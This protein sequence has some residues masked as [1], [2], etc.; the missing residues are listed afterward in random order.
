V[1]LK[2]AVAP[3][4]PHTY[5]PCCLILT[6]PAAVS[7]KSRCGSCEI[8]AVGPAKH[9]AYPAKA[10]FN[11]QNPAVCPAKP[12]CVSCRMSCRARSAGQAGQLAVY[13]L[14]V[15]NSVEERLL[16]LTDR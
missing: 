16:Q 7:A 13:R 8:P 11:L 14:V 15:R 3:V 6:N 1:P 4:C 5:M 12:C 9:A 2:A 10:T